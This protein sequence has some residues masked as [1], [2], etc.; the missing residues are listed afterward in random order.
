MKVDKEASIK[1]ALS[2]VSLFA[3]SSEHCLICS[4]I[5]NVLK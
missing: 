2:I 3:G 1:H 4:W 5:V